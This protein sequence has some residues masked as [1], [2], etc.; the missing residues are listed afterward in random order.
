MG[1]TSAGSLESMVWLYRTRVGPFEIDQVGGDIARPERVL[2][3][4]LNEWCD[5]VVASAGLGTSNL[6]RMH[7]QSSRVYRHFQYEG[8]PSSDSADDFQSPVQPHRYISLRI[9]PTMRFFQKRIPAADIDDAEH[10]PPAN[11]KVSRVVPFESQTT[12]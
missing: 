5:E 3:E 12:G 10:G 6:K 9:E 7:K 4:S 1:R 2:Y 11:A 8:E